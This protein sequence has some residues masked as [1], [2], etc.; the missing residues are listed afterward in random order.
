MS[1][2][3]SN[4]NV[5]QGSLNRL[6]GSLFFPDFPAL[7]ITSPYLGEAGITLSFEG[8][9][10]L[11]VNTMTGAV[12]SPEPYVMCTVT[13]NLMKTQGLA[14]QFEQ[15]RQTTSLLGSI[16]VRTDA[17]TLPNYTLTN[18]A[19]Q[20]VRELSFAGRDAGFVV[21]FRGYY[22]INNDLWNLL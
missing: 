17:V 7:N 16:T 21:M 9:S 8:E 10:T 19:L 5:V 18:C 14:T 20:N 12:T 22:Q 4:P 2:T 6:R 13:A 1:G 15:Q 11:F 3:Q